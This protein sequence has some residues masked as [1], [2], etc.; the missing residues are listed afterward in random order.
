MAPSRVSAFQPEQLHDAVH[1]GR[2]TT[3]TDLMTIHPICI[4]IDVAK[5]HLDLF[6]PVTGHHRIDNTGAAIE[7]W[8]QPLTGTD[9]F[10]VFEA[11]GGYDWVLRCALGQARIRHA[12]LNPTQ[13]RRYAQAT[14]RLA[15]TDRID[16]AM[17]CEL[18]E[19][20]APPP[21]DAVDASRKHLS[22]LHKRRD[23]L[24]AERSA[25]KVRLSEARG[26]CQTVLAS[27]ATH[28]A[29]LD[30]AIDELDAAILALIEQDSEL[31]RQ[32]ALLRTAPG[33][34]FVSAVTL[35]AQMP[36]LGLR[37]PGSIAAL[38]GLAPFNCDSGAMRGQRHIRGG[39]GRVRRALYM[40]ALSAVRTNAR[41]RAFYQRLL[42]AGKAKKLALIAVAR[43]LITILNA[44][45]RDAQPFIA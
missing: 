33:I 15:K 12:R 43:K 44:M 32:A 10:I 5:A 39:R 6:H 8:L 20:L 17:L 40:A 34:G 4:G 37:R 35:L 31:Q 45:L 22:D 29:W 27:L 30:E 38:C 16:A 25:E 11:T 1:S 18:G 42:D 24:I 19:R 41:I 26:L 23:Q 7:Q 3:G 36:E 21:Q 2:R 14:G 13:A 9:P 28:I